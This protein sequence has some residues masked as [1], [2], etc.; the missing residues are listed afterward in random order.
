MVVVALRL[1]E[2]GAMSRPRLLTVASRHISAP[3]EI[4]PSPIREVA[5]AIV[6]EVPP[7]LIEPVERRVADVYCVTVPQTVTAAMADADFARH[8]RVVR[9]KIKPHI[10][11]VV[12]AI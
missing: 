8:I 1:I 3:I 7:I 12:L 6:N 2:L 4:C 5:G 9:Q 11:T 10:K